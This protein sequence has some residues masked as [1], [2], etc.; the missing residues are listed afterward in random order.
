MAIPAS[1]II[2]ATAIPTAVFL[3]EAGGFFSEDAAVFI[4][5]FQV[6]HNI[7]GTAGCTKKKNA[8]TDGT[9]AGLKK[10]KGKDQCGK[11]QGVF[12]P[13]IWPQCRMIALSY[14][15]NYRVF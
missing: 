6:V 10:G 3:K 11:H 14:L 9:A 15:K 2:T 8:A 5:V 1:K 7:H 13:L 4:Q 12:C